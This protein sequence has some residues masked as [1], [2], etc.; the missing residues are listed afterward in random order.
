M[1]RIEL[2]SR[3]DRAAAE[4]LL[5]TLRDAVAAGDVAIDGAQVAQI[6]QA[7]L[8]ML[9]ATRRSAESAGHG[10]ALTASDAMRATLAI[11]GAEALVDGDIL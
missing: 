7:M 8:Q 1:S 4:A 3:A 5:P 11:A 6:G 10:F 2:P 9:I